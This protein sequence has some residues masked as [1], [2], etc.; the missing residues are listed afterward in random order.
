MEALTEYVKNQVWLLE[1]PIRFEGMDLFGRMTIIRLENGDLLIHDPCKITDA[2]RQQIDDIG[3]V[4][5]IVAPG[6]YH[7]L[8]VTDFQT[9]YPQAETFLCPGLERKRPDIPF[10]WILGNKPDPRWAD[11]IDQVVVSGTKYM[12][13]VAFFHKPSKT[14]ILVDLLENIG[15]DYRHHANWVLRFWW[16]FVFRMWNKPKPAPEYQMGWGNKQIVQTALYKILGWQAERAIIA[17]GETIEEGVNEVLSEAW[18]KVL[19]A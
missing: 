18:K 15:D 12:W 16:K 6:S 2:I 13:E 4:K 17:H 3:P 5:Y 19:K 8:F 14:L 9:K 1:Y 11:E 10:D 7:H